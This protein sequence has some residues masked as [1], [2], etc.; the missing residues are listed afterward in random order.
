MLDYLVQKEH[1]RRLGHFEAL[2]VIA[3]KKE[4][5]GKG[6]LTRMQKMQKS[7]RGSGLLEGLPEGP[8]WQWRVAAL[9]L[10]KQKANARSSNN[11]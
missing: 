6:N 11:L 5:Q 7:P 1:S 4:R 3:L 8:P 10:L 9:V 2:N